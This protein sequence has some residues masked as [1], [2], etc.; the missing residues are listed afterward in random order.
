M[1]SGIQRLERQGVF[2]VNVGNERNGRKRN[3][4]RQCRRGLAVRNGDT[5]DFASSLGELS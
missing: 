1:N 3:D 4:V 2:E 5:D